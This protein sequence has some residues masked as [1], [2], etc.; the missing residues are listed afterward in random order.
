MKTNT[1]THIFDKALQSFLIKPFIYAIKCH[2]L[3]FKY[4]HHADPRSL[5]WD[6]QSTNFNR[7]ALVNLLLRHI[8]N[9]SYLEIGCATNSLFNSIPCMNKTGVDPALG[10][11]IRKTSDEFFTLN[12]NRFNVIFIDGLH[13]YEQV[14]RDVI[15]SIKAIDNSGW[16]VLHD[17]LPR[18]WVEQHVPILTSGDWTGD[19]WKVAFELSKTE[20]I[21]FKI[22]KIDH[23]VGVVKVLNSNVELKNL[24]EH[25]VTKEFSY[26]YDNLAN[27]PIIEWSDAQDWLSS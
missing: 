26:Y 7:I 6:W 15:N 4:R 5:S 17:M 23:G 27:L 10:G 24:F 1:H 14:R 9:P 3:K 13:T 20:G 2:L 8:S 11:N 25:L 21:E 18:D 19:V 12:K 22:I 16:I